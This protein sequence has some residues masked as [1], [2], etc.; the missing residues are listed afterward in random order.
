MASVYASMEYLEIVSEYI[1]WKCVENFHLQG[2]CHISELSSNWLA[3]AE[4]VSNFDSISLIFFKLSTIN[5]FNMSKHLGVFDNYS[6]LQ[7]VKVGDRI[8]VKLIEVWLFCPSLT[9]QMPYIH[10]DDAERIL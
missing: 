5:A 1:F 3:K 8:D 7:V 10:N 4:D 6:L 2:L 9:T